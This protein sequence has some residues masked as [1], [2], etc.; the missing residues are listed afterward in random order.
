MDDYRI[1]AAS[2]SEWA[3]LRITGLKQA[4]LSEYASEFLRAYHGSPDAAKAL[5]EA[6]LPGWDVLNIGQDDCY[7][8]I[9]GVKKIDGGA[10][11]WW[12]RN[13]NNP[14]RAW[15]LAILRAKIN[16]EMTQ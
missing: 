7:G 12:G 15:L 11:V 13:W 16:K 9:V 6:V 1:E 10:G 4:D 3:D 14:A 5:H 8:W 2:K